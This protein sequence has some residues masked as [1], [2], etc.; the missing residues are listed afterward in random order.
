MKHPG[1]STVVPIWFIPHS[2]SIQSLR[3]SR[4]ES[5][6]KSELGGLPEA[7][8]FWQMTVIPWFTDCL[9]HATRRQSIQGEAVIPDVKRRCTN[10]KRNSGNDAI[11][12]FRQRGWYTPVDSRRIV[13]AITKHLSLGLDALSSP[14]ASRLERSRGLA[15]EM[16]K[17]RKLQ[18]R[19]TR[20]DGSC[21]LP[22]S[23][24]LIR[25]NG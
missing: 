6:I 25:K 13:S 21:N 17:L 4:P 22:I 15:M 11:N 7:P 20:D 9:R 10:A 14:I 24:S 2:N 12:P 8:F 19:C 1:R 16:R 5:G 23:R 3:Y 18:D